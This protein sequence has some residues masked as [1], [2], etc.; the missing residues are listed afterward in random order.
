[1]P[2]K[3]RPLAEVLGPLE[4]EVMDIIWG[5][6]E[7]TVRDVYGE[8]RTRRPIAYTTVMT[9]MG[10][11][12]DKGYLARVEDRQ[13]HRYSPLLSRER[14]ARSTVQSVMDWLVGQFQEPTVAYLVDRVDKGDPELLDTL[15]Q[16]IEK[17]REKQSEDG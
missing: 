13:A 14:Y 8:L 6:G 3:A 12:A 16:A 2:S 4:T 11:L 7:V 15:R 9:T 10:R 5:R 1:M 17:Q